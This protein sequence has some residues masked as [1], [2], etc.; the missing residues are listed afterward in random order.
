M[1]RLSAL[2]ELELDWKT[3]PRLS[4]WWHG[5]ISSD[6]AFITALFAAIGAGFAAGL[7]AGL[8]AGVP[9]SAASVIGLFGGVAG[10]G[11][12]LLSGL[13][14]S[15][16]VK[17]LDKSVLLTSAIASKLVGRSWLHELFKN[18]GKSVDY[19]EIAYRLQE[20]SAFQWLENQQD[21]DDKRLKFIVDKAFANAIDVDAEKA[22]FL[23][24]AR[25]VCLLPDTAPDASTVA[26][27]RA[28]AKEWFDV[29]AIIAAPDQRDVMDEK[30]ATEE[31]KNLLAV[32]DGSDAARLMAERAMLEE[33]AK[34]AM[35]TGQTALEPEQTTAGA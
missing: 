14:M 25:F 16:V 6:K 26:R 7:T 10:L 33:A 17:R 19:K 34:H 3:Q 4:R 18:H 2:E 35:A 5:L 22:R 32:D 20:Q 1:D 29:D 8:L 13:A 27:A 24:Y 15:L 11:V 12:G 23:E 30:R 9:G 21:W 31:V 28:K